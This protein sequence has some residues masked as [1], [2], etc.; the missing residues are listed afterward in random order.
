MANFAYT[1]VTN[2]L[3]TAAL[4]MSTAD[5]RA[6]AVMTNT[7]ADTEKD[8]NFIA[9]FTTLDEFNGANYAR[10]TFATQTVTQD[11]ANDRT[12]LD[13]EDIAYTA[14]GAGTRQ[15]AG[16]VIYVHVTNDSDSYPIAFIDDNMPFTAQGTNVTFVVNTEG[17]IQISA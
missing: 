12:E 3:A 10:T 14:L 8:V 13:T 5:I 15:M 9:D 7:T 4:N 17:L 6:L 11:N 2:K 16:H 1:K